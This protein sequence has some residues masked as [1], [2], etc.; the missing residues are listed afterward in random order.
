[1][2]Y[3]TLIR[4]LLGHPVEYN[5]L[6]I[7]PGGTLGPVLGGALGR[8]G[9]VAVPD[10]RGEAE[11]DLLLDGP[12]LELDEA[13]LLEVLLAL[14]LL[15]RR[16]VRLVG[17]EAPL[18]VAVLAVDLVVVLRLLHHHHLVDAP[19]AGRRDGADVEGDVAALPLSAAAVVEPNVQSWYLFFCYLGCSFFPSKLQSDP[20]AMVHQLSN[21]FDGLK[22]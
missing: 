20:W 17:G 22:K 4:D 10:E 14:L 15:L 21:N 13:V 6:A 19:L 2:E 16:V 7:L 3:P 12:R 18:L 11:L 5:F 8:A 1:M 9:Q